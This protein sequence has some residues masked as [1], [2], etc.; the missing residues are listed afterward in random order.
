MERCCREMAAGRQAALGERRR[1]E[2]RQGSSLV[3]KEEFSVDVFP[4]AVVICKYECVSNAVQQA[5]K[6]HTIEMYEANMI[7]SFGMYSV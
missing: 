1:D 7:A 3:F 2:T 4:E 6:Y 5:S